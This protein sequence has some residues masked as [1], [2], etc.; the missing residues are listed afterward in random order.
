MDKQNPTEGI[1]TTDEV[2]LKLRSAALRILYERKELCADDLH[3]VSLCGR[4]P[5]VIGAVLAAMQRDGV[6]R[7]TAYRKSDRK[8]CHHRPIMVWKGWA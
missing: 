5:R 1:N 4:D 2:C 6:I 7:P 8:E 3:T